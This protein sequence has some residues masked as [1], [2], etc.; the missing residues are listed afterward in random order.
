MKFLYS[1]VLTF[2]LL[3]VSS[4]SSPVYA[5]WLDTFFN[6]QEYLLDF[7]DVA[8][9]VTS[10]ML[11]SGFS[12]YLQYGLCENRWADRAYFVEHQYLLENPDVA[13]AVPSY[14]CSGWEH[15]NLY[16]AD[17]GR[18]PGN[19][20]N[21][22]FAG[23]NDDFYLPNNPDVA[24]AVE[25]GVFGSG[26]EHWWAFGAYEERNPSEEFDFGFYGITN[27]DVSAAVANGAFRHLYD[28]YFKFGRIEGRRAAQEEH[29]VLVVSIDLV[30]VDAS[31]EWSV[32]E[33]E[34]VMFSNAD[35]V[36]MRLQRY[37]LDS[38][39]WPGDINDIVQI[40]INQTKGKLACEPLNAHQCSYPLPNTPTSTAAATSGLL[41]R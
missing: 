36:S 11:T 18:N 31:D 41:G 16:G 1:L 19:P 25:V 30:D 6:E 35:S 3:F 27:P 17:E 8:D 4:C 5:S 28:H 21:T 34:A 22:H 39:R 29:R 32:Q 20:G 14:F 26:Y 13:D 38:V 2:G 23:Y 9:A 37:S 24:A 15:F 40:N 33:L 10:G 12:H 7:P